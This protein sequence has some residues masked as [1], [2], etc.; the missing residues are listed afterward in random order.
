[1]EGLH[2]EINNNDDNDVLAIG[3]IKFSKLIQRIHF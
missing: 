1:M 2:K 3:R